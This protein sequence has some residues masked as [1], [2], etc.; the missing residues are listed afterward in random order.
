MRCY[1][2]Y[3]RIVF[4]AHRANGGKALHDLRFALLPE[5]RADYCASIDL[6]ETALNIKIDQ[7]AL[8]FA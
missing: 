3:S 2:W 7:I 1:I 8:G 5:R 6:Y 4:S